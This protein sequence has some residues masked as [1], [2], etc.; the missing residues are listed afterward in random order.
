[1]G[2]RL[3]VSLADKA[4]ACKDAKVGTISLSCKD[5]EKGLSSVVVSVFI[6]ISVSVF[7][8]VSE[9]DPSSFGLVSSCTLL[10]VV[11][12]ASRFGVVDVASRFGVV[13]VASRFGVVVVASRFGVVVSVSVSVSACVVVF[14]ATLFGSVDANVLS[15]VSGCVGKA[16]EEEEEEEEVGREEE[17][18]ISFAKQKQKQ[19]Q[20]QKQKKKKKKEN[21][22]P[23]SCVFFHVLCRTDILFWHELPLLL[24]LGPMFLGMCAQSMCRKTGSCV[25]SGFL[26]FAFFGFSFCLYLCLCLCLC[27]GLCFGFCVGL[28]LGL[29]LGLCIGLCFGFCLGLCCRIVGCCYTRGRIVL[30]GRG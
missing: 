5:E 20:Q 4:D 1:M 13:V 23:K 27:V 29:C 7:V 30:L 22:I 8:S 28:C 25:V 18:S 14:V 26:L 2:E 15:L 3:G 19:Q 9:E 11:V 6:P 17:A 21:P 10:A 16:K 12:V 24:W